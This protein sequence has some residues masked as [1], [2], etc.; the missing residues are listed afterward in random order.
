MFI[1]ETLFKI[2]KTIKVP[3]KKLYVHYK[4]NSNTPFFYFDQFI[5]NIQNI[6][7]QISCTFYGGHYPKITHHHYKNSPKSLDSNPKYSNPRAKTS[8]YNLHAIIFKPCFI[9]HKSKLPCTCT[10]NKKNQK[11]KAALH[12]K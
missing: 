7:H 5:Q 1:H 9:C 12:N 8:P 10:I 11:S 2:Q 6:I 3:L 4:I